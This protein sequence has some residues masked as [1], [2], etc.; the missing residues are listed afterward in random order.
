MDDTHSTTHEG[1]E[2]TGASPII[3]TL[4]SFESSRLVINGTEDD[5]E[6]PRAGTRRQLAVLE[7]SESYNTNLLPP[8]PLYEEESPYML[9]YIPDLAGGNIHEESSLPSSEPQA[10]HYYPGHHIVHPPPL[11]HAESAPV[12]NDPRRNIIHKREDITH[13]TNAE[14]SLMKSSIDFSEVSLE[15]VIGGG[16]FGQVWKATWRS[17][18]VAVKILTG[19]AQREIC[20]KG[21]LEEFAAEINM[22][23]VR[24]CE[25]RV[26]C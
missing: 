13:C 14:S 19:S 24:F 11:E 17:T 7:Q 10:K 8:P 18:P 15:M 6:T 20:D 21:I 22:L 4:S 12:S 2:E 25:P 5:F 3:Y 1:D 23:K 16:G 26:R 9:P